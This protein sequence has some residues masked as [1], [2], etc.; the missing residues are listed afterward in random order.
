MPSKGDIKLRSQQLA[1]WLKAKG[2][3]RTSGMCPWGCG[4]H[5]PNGGPALLSHLSRCH[6]NAKRDARRK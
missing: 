2:V 4:S 3:E 1:A 6:G 5:I